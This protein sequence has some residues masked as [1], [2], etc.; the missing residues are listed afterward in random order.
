MAHDAASDVRTG[1]GGR[2]IVRLADRIVARAAGPIA[3]PGKSAAACREQNGG[4]P[5]A[6]KNHPLPGV[7]ERQSLDL[8]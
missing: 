7:A 3:Y 8:P 5:G 4:L 1:E 6:S 2:S